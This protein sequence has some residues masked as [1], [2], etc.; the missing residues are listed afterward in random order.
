MTATVFFHPSPYAIHQRGKELYA[1]NPS[2]NRTVH[3]ETPAVHRLENNWF[4]DTFVSCTSAVRHKRAI[5]PRFVRSLH[6]NHRF[7]SSCATVSKTCETWSFR[8]RE[9]KGIGNDS[10]ERKHV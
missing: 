10:I 7:R 9:E 4:R 1:Q 6:R 8:S 2:Q 5:Q 3:H